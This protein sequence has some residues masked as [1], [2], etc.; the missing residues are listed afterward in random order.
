MTRR[1]FQLLVAA[2]VL[3]L[4]P[5]PV[6]A[7][8]PRTGAPDDWPEAMPEMIHW[9]LLADQL[10]YRVNDG[11]DQAKWEVEGWLGGDTH[12][13]WLESEGEVNTTGSSEGDAEVQLFYG[14]HFAPFWDVK[15]GARQ[16]FLFGSGPNRERTFAAIGVEGLAPGWFEVEPMLFVSDDGDVS[17]RLTADYDLLLT[18]RLVVQPRMELN[19]AAHD[20]K[21]FGIERG[22]NDI[23]LGLR[24]RYEIRREFAPYV[25]VNWLRKLGNT[26]DL[27]RREGE[28]ASVVGFVAGLRV[29]F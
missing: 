1:T 29:W 14:Y 8:N 10:E 17:A 28:D 18:Q 12:R 26:A 4:G 2:W 20:A 19:V 16:D 25:G 22:F 5:N 11:D 21:K 24:L 27:A 23:E 3:A 6:F 9:F 7:E 15:V 13:V